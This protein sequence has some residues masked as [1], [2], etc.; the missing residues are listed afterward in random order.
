MEQEG[1]CNGTGGRSDGMKE[2]GR[3]ADERLDDNGKGKV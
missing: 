3:I 2:I 1:I